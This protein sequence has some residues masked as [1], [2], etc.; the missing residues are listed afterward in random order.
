[1]YKKKLSSKKIHQQSTFEE[2]LLFPSFNEMYY[3]AAFSTVI[4]LT[5]FNPGYL[6]YLWDFIAED[7]RGLIFPVGAAGLAYFMVKKHRFSTEAKMWICMLYYGFFALIAFAS[8]ENRPTQTVYGLLEYINEMLI[9]LLLILA[10]IRGVITFIVFRF[11]WERAQKYITANFKD[12][13]YRPRGFIA[14]TLLALI[15]MYILSGYYDNDAQLAL[16]TYIYSL[17][18]MRIVDNFSF[19]LLRH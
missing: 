4:V 5:I 17:G 9:R 1:M 12:E 18:V 7:I 11:R 2:R 15:F 10:V 8:L 16:Y 19:R 13:Q 14:V 6:K 3:M